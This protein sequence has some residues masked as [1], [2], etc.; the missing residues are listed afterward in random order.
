MLPTAREPRSLQELD[1]NVRLAEQLRQDAKFTALG[2][3]LPR[4]LTDLIAISSNSPQDRDQAEALMLRACHMA[5]VS[6]NLLGRV[7]PIYR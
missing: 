6:S 3:V 7:R 4:I 2:E 1:A 5:R